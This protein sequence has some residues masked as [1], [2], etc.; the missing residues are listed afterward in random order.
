MDACVEWDS[1]PLKQKGG[2]GRLAFI[3]RSTSTAKSQASR[4]E[5]TK[6]PALAPEVNPYR[7]IPL[8]L[9]GYTNELGEALKPFLR[10]PPL[11]YI[12]PG[13]YAVASSYVLV[14][15]NKHASISSAVTG[16]GYAGYFVDGLI[17]QMLASVVVPGFVVNRVVWGVGRAGGT[18][19]VQT[20]AGL[21]SI[22]FIIKPIDAG[23]EFMM[24]KTVRKLFGK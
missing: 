17:W 14:D 22:P 13:S 20:L 5:G 19:Q 21:A 23:V 1:A 3:N 8:R 10:T 16:G 15:S 7:Q 18:K 2:E 24:D 12:Y 4:P 6:K 9:F 11:S